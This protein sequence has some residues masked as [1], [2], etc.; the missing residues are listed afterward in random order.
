[1]NCIICL[2]QIT[3][4]DLGIQYLSTTK[5][6]QIL[7]ETFEKKNAEPEIIKYCLHCLGS[8]LYKDLGNNVKTINFEKILFLLILLQKKYYS[9]SDILI[10]INYIAGYL[11]KIIRDK[12]AKEKLYQ[13]IGE[14]IKIQDWNIQLIIMTLKLI[15]EILQSGSVQIDDIFEETMHSMLNLIRNH[16]D[17]DIVILCYSILSLFSKIYIYS[18]VMV[19]NNIVEMIKGTLEADFDIKTKFTLRDI[20]IKIMSHLTTD[21]NNARKLSEVLMNKL[22]ND[23]N[24]EEFA[25]QHQDI[26][27]NNIL[28][29]N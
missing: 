9:N 6:Q 12:V 8:Y 18:Y 4:I 20:L 17:P 27:V 16:N 10:N 29:R 25:T 7:L 22:I 1:M 23:L 19:S 21:M 28:Y 11:I 15:Y 24:N 14:S 26:L 3:M 13:L 5:F 2:D